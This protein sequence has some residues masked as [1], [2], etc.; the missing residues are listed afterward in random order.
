MEVVRTVTPTYWDGES[1]WSALGINQSR[2]YLD[3][4]MIWAVAVVSV[5]LSILFYQA[6]TVVE[7]RVLA[8]AG[9][10]GR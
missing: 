10:W 9:M 7:H 4:G 2:G 5:I 6:V 3:Y 8:R 1:I